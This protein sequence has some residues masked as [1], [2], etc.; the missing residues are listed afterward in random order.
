MSSGDILV[1]GGGLSYSI[2]TW[3]LNLMMMMMMIF[4]PGVQEEEQHQQRCRQV[5]CSTLQLQL[6]PQP[7]TRRPSDNDDD[8][9]C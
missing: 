4:E 5:S 2:L 1:G 8:Q 3:I 7:L 6:T 9:I